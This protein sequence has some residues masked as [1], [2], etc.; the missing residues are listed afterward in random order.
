MSLIWDGFIGK[1]QPTLAGK[2]LFMDR[3][4]TCCV[5]VMVFE[6]HQEGSLFSPTEQA[7]VTCLLNQHIYFL[8]IRCYYNITMHYTLYI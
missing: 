6:C 7:A 1:V 2:N 4:G 5:S 3:T 8:T